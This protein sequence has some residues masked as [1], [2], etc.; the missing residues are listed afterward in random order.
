MNTLITTVVVIST[1][2]TP[3]VVAYYEAVN[4]PLPKAVILT[5][6]DAELTKW[7]EALATCESHN[8]EKA[9]NHS[10]GGSRSVGY[11]QY[12]D[13]TWKHYND[14][15]HLPYTN[16]DIWKKE[17]QIAVTKEVI[18]REPKG[19]LNWRNCTTNPKTRNYAGLP[20]NMP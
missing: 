6:Y 20:P 19:Y 7:I 18:K 10:D 9:I 14:K 11:V 12:K 13:G 2:F 15:F 1:L 3:Q 5:T 17:A 8:N 4:E 16:D